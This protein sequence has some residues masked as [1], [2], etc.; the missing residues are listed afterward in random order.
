MRQ[1]WEGNY[2]VCVITGH[3]PTFEQMQVLV[4]RH[5]ARPLFPVLWRDWTAVRLVRET[6]EDSWDQ[7]AEARLTALCVEERLQELPTLWDRQRGTVPYV[8]PARPD[9]ALVLLRSLS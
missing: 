7:D 5:K 1:E 2:E 4:S 6:V 9:I 3:H 8:T